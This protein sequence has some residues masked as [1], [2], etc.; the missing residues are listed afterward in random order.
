MKTLRIAVDIVLYFSFCFLAGTGIMLEF[1]FE[2]GE[3]PQ[4]VLCFGK[5]AWETAHLW[6][7]VAAILAFIIHFW[8]NSRAFRSAVKTRAAYIALIVAGF[9]GAVLLALWPTERPEG[10]GGDGRQAQIRARL[11][12]PQM[13]ADR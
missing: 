2:K 13:P 1:A 9:G 4:S 7:G 12:A 3:G 11:G 10:G 8:L 6:V 5:K